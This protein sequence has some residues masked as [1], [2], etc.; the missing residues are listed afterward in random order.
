MTVRPEEVF[1]SVGVALSEVMDPCSVAAGRPTSIV[2]L[3]LLVSAHLEDDGELVIV[4]RTTFPGCTMAPHFT[5]A[6]ETCAGK[7]PGVRSV[8][9]EI[10]PDFSWQ[11]ISPTAEIPTK[12]H[13]E[14]IP[15]AIRR[16]MGS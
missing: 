15:W 7:L 11:P 8:R 3:G 10:D 14:T 4:L 5:Q 13:G 2:D 16:S 1:E 9:V 12:A 6:A